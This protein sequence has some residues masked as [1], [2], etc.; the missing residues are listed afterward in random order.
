[1][2]FAYTAGADY[3]LVPPGGVPTIYFGTGTGESL[4]TNAETGFTG[5]E[6]WT[7]TDGATFAPVG[8][9][10]TVY[11]GLPGGEDVGTYQIVGTGSV[12][13][14]GFPA[15]MLGMG[16]TGLLGLRRKFSWA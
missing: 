8:T 15:L 16:L 10:G 12:P 5:S 3:G 7:L 4:T 9:T 6:T 14:G 1:M 13:D 2:N 11:W